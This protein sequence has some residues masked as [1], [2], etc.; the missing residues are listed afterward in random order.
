MYKYI[1]FD[2]DGT[3]TDPKE[4]IVNSFLYALDKMNIKVS[5]KTKLQEFIGPPLTDTFSQYYHLNEADTDKAVKFYR[6][7][8]SV[9]GLFENIVYNGIKD[10]L[11]CLKE[12]GKTLVIATSKPEKFTIEILKHFDLYE[13]FTFV[14]G[15]TLDHKRSEKK[16][17]ISHAINSLSLTNLD[18]IIMVGDRKH[19]VLGAKANNIKS[20]GVLYGYGSK[21]E[22]ENAKADYIVKNPKELVKLLLEI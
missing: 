14:S 13:Y 6:E 9:K 11:K 8:F 3:L 19:D 10:V 5:E 20:I 16:D 2:L 12:R 4:G 1:F 17:I 7:Y 15:A 18:E 21:E 22:L